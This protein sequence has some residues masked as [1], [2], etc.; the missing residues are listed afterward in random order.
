MLD[1]ALDL[2]LNAS[3]IDLGGRAKAR[4]TFRRNIRV[5]RDDEPA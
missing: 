1:R 4:E 2:A 3:G 5:V